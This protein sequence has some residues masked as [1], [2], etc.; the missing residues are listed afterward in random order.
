M[1][2]GES[3][4]ELIIIQEDN[5]MRKIVSTNAAPAAIGPYSQ[6]N[7]YGSLIFTSGQVPLDP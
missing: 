3:T 7:I 6:G 2:S 1:K 4:I 5:H